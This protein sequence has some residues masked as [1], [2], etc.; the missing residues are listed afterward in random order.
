MQ[1]CSKKASIDIVKRLLE[2][3][4]KGAKV[5]NQQGQFPLHIASQFYPNPSP[6]II[7]I[8]LEEYPSAVAI[9][10]NDGELPLHVACKREEKEKKILPTMKNILGNSP[11]MQGTDG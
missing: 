6:E 10:D 8:L 2:E 4:P 3:Y 7:N 5:Q 9:K 1:Q 11:Y